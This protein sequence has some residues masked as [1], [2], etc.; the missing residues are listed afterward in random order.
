MSKESNAT[1]VENIEEGVQ[2]EKVNINNDTDSNVRNDFGR[3]RHRDR[4]RDGFDPGRW[5]FGML[6][7]LAGVYLLAVNLNLIPAWVSWGNVWRLWPG[8]IIISGVSMLSRRNR[9]LG[10]ILTMATLVVLVGAFV[11]LQQNNSSSPNI[12]TN[13]S[14]LNLDSGVK[15]AQVQLDFGAVDMKVRDLDNDKLWQ[16]KLDSNVANLQTSSSNSGEIQTASLSQQGLN[17]GVF[18]MGVQNKLDLK[19]SKKVKLD[20]GIKS[21]ASS[22][23]LDLQDLKLENLSIDSGASSLDLK[24]GNQEN[25]LRGEIKA[26]ASSVNIKVP[27]N[28]GVRLNIDNGLSSKDLD[29]FK[30]LNEQTYQ[31]ENFDQA[32]KKIELRLDLGVSSLNVDRE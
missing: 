29:D 18:V 7:V 16:A 28:V 10:A 26:G 31:T 4:D 25:S 1:K 24:L 17:Q 23:D 12:R 6:F 19:L 27:R 2:T 14:D 11:L 8:F 3:R 30:Q 21:G 13:Y 15:K 22:L 20:L 32:S 5:I 9:V